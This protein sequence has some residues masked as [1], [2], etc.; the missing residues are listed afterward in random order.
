MFRLCRSRT[1]KSLT[2]LLLWRT[3]NTFNCE[4]I[5]VQRARATRSEAQCTRA[6]ARRAA[7]QLFW[8][9]AGRNILLAGLDQ[10][11]G[12]LEFFNVDDLATLRCQQHFLCNNV[13]WDATGRYVAT[14]VD[15]SRD[16]EHGYIV[17]SFTGEMMFRCRA[18]PHLLPTRLPCCTS[19]QRLPRGPRSGASVVIPHALH[20]RAFRHAGVAST[21]S[22]ALRGVPGHRACCRRKRTE[23]FSVT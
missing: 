16:M 18:R 1:H 10:T 9:P 17:W 20:V 8:S 15:D 2:M 14:W 5:C 3:P 11:S 4:C 23:R 19:Y 6:R 7:S 21:L 22:G 13:K 12:Q